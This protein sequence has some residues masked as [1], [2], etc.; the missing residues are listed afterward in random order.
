MCCVDFLM[1]DGNLIEY[2]NVF[3]FL[4]L[5]VETGVQGGKQRE[6]NKVVV[7]NLSS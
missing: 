7:C 1:W 5:T 2:M 6:N 3:N 4:F